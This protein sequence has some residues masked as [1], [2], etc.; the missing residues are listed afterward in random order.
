MIAMKHAALSLL[1]LSALLL[2]C[3]PDRLESVQREGKP[4]I[5]MVKQDDPEMNAAIAKAQ[6]TL[7]EFV[8][9]LQNLRPTMSGVSVK[10]RFEDTNGSEHMWIAEPTWD[11]KA[12]SG[13]LANEPNWVKTVKLGDPVTVPVSELSDWKYVE[14]GK[15]VGGYTLRLLMERM[16]PE[17]RAAVESSGGFKL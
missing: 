10:A 2:G 5:S 8:K 6:Q 9:A 4:G 7:P 3:R 17:E 1:L 14:Q 16:S 12:I 11:G 13:V 15:L